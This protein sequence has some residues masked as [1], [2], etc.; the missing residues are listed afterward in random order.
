MLGRLDN[1]LLH[2]YLGANRQLHLVQVR[3]LLRRDLYAG[4]WRAT[5]AGGAAGDRHELARQTKQIA[6]TIRLRLKVRQQA[7][8]RV[9]KRLVCVERL[10]ERHRLGT[11]R[12]V[13]RQRQLKRLALRKLRIRQRHGIDLQ[14]AGLALDTTLEID[15]RR[16]R[17]RARLQHKREF[18]RRAGLNPDIHRL[19][20][21][22]AQAVH[23]LVQ[24]ILGN[25]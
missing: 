9:L 16:D 20:S 25:R 4:D 3:A 7:L 15:I 8:C 17:A 13:D 6:L 12:R 11:R 19:L 24:K 21:W 22:A 23:D 1:A 2:L 10:L 18:T 14:I 5:R